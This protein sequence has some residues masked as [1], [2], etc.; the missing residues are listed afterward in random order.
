LLVKYDVLLGVREEDEAVRDA[1]L[2]ERQLVGRLCGVLRFRRNE[3][4]S[5]SLYADT[6]IPCV[7]LDL[8]LTLQ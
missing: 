3:R 7:D 1:G 6:S 5:V 4:I 8:R 2:H